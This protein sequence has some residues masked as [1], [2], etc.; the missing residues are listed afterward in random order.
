[1]AAD[2]VIGLARRY[3]FL[4]REH[5]FH[6]DR[7]ILFGSHARGD[8]QADSD[9]DLLVPSPNFDTLTWKQE[10]LLWALTAQIDTRLEPIPCSEDQWRTDH[11]SP[12]IDIARQ[13]GLVVEADTMKTYPARQEFRV[14]S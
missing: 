1:M 13:E 8:A 9:I 11:V 14:P 10:E 7:V 5:G 4:L 2:I 6:I 3:L 12:L